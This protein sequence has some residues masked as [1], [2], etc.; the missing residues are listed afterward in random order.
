M[1]GIIVDIWDGDE[2]FAEYEKYYK[3]RLQLTGVVKSIKWGVKGKNCEMAQI[4]CERDMILIVP[5]RIADI[6]NKLEEIN[7][8]IK[9]ASLTGI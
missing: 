2:R 4:G 7:N 3:K 8:W 9:L 1:N 6:T 5:D